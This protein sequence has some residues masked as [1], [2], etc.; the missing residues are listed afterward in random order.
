MLVELRICDFIL[1]KEQQISLE[2][3]LNVLTG[4]TGS[5]KSII[6]Q[7]IQVLLGGK[8]K[9]DVLRPGADEAVIEALF[10]LENVPEAIKSELPDLLKGDELLI[11][12][13]ITRNGRSKVSVNGRLSSLSLLE[14]L[15]PRLVNICSQNQQVRL[16]DPKYHLQTLDGYLNKPDLVTQYEHAY[17]E[18]LRAKQELQQAESSFT[19]NSQRQSEFA[20]IAEELSEIALT[21]GRRDEL[22][23]ESK[24]L[25]GGERLIEVCTRL[26]Q[27]FSSEGTLLNSVRGLN[28]LSAEL[29]KIDFDFGKQ[30]SEKISEIKGL[31]NDCESSVQRYQSRIELDDKRLQQVRDELAELARVLRKYKRDEQELSD[32]LQEAKRA[33]AGSEGGVNIEKL[34]V[35]LKSLESKA[36]S[37][38]VKLSDARKKAALQLSK[39]VVSGLT[40]L[41]LKGARFEV[42]FQDKA[43]GASGMD[44]A[45][46]RL[47]ANKGLALSSLKDVASGGEL[48]RILLV[49][50]QVLREV[51][52]VNVLVFDEVDTGISGS[53]AR[54][55]GEKLKELARFSQVLCITHLPQVASLADHHLVVNKS[56]DKLATTIVKTVEGNSRV[57][58]IAR[59]LSG[60][61]VTASTRESARELLSSK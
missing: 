39:E 37:A 11:S 58:E 22:E 19:Q 48:S 34:R 57:D 59:M 27:E 45:E 51:S 52:G 13:S 1:I 56:Q 54:A 23:R 30:I 20:A 6:L 61:R 18:Y 29:S 10:R 21:P 44:Q 3:G 26:G 32:L 2:P 55:V 17:Q 8:P 50:K 35:Q 9:G 36:H 60:H 47:S 53:V 5:G 15:R 46:F 28:A 16:L 42:L 40:D 7:A 4:E 24:R 33:L 12:R 25:Q 43:L 41:N 38:A 14:E 31:V 49:L